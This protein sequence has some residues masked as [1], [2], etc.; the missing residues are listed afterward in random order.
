MKMKCRHKKLVKSQQ[1]KVEDRYIG[2]IKLK[3][4]IDK[5]RSVLNL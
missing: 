2:F 3:L 1:K 4:N 5:V